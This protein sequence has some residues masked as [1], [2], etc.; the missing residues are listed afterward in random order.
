MPEEFLM[1]QMIVLE[2][3]HTFTKINNLKFS[4][5]FLFG[6]KILSENFQ[7]YH[8]DDVAEWLRRWTANPMCSARV[9]SNP[10]VIEFLFDDQFW[11]NNYYLFWFLGEVCP[12]SDHTIC[13]DFILLRI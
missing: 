10:I 8:E 7:S 5:I 4:E 9:G 2:V 12:I 6:K 3:Y 1:S 11:P 13:E